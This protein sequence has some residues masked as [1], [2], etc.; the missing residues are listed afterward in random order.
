MRRI[1]PLE[2]LLT[3]LFTL[4]AG[5][6]GRGGDRTS[7]TEG[8]VSERV[9]DAPDDGCTEEHPERRQNVGKIG[10]A[11][12]SCFSDDATSLSVENV[13]SLVLIVKD[14]AGDAFDLTVVSGGA[15]SFADSMVK[16]TTPALCSDIDGWCRMPPRATVIV[17]SDPTPRVVVYADP[18][19]TAAATAAAS[20]GSWVQ[21][22]LTT[23]AASFSAAVRGCANAVA[24]VADDYAYVEDA[25][26]AA[27]ETGTACTGLYR[28][29]TAAADDV[30]PPPTQATDDVLRHARGFSSNLRRELALLSAIR[31]AT[32]IP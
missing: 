11:F 18:L 28:E 27:V 9:P 2:L 30:P 8:D 7:S 19:A 16:Q 13:S 4:V 1:P 3:A 10:G 29:V 21:S 25:M 12:V 32:R 14:D 5:C 15:N 17:D 26:R 23:R 22:T 24:A 20:F 31:V 6:G